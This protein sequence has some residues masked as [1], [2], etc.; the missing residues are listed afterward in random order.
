M[1]IDANIRDVLQD[2]YS[3]A[4]VSAILASNADPM[5]NFSKTLTST[6]NF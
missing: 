1:K 2:D 5:L 6:L 4:E 3:E